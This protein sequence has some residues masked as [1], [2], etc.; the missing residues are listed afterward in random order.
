VLPAVDIPLPAP[1]REGCG[2]GATPDAPDGALFLLAWLFARVARS[3][4][5]RC[6]TQKPESLGARDGAR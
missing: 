3:R 6:H 2:C 4:R 5:A 1:K